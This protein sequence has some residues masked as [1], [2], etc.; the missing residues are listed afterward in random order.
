VGRFR[1][2]DIRAIRLILDER[3]PLDKAAWRLG[4][5]YHGVEQ[6]VA[7]DQLG[8]AADQYCIHRYGSRQ[9][10]NSALAAF[11]AELAAACSAT[12]PASPLPLR[13]AVKVIGGRLKPWAPIF[14]A[15]AERAIPF[16]YHEGS[17]PLTERITIDRS[18]VGMLAD[19]Q[20]E[21]ADFPSYAFATTMTRVDAGEVLNLIAKAYTPLLCTLPPVEG[22]GTEIWLS[23]VEQLASQHIAGAEIG[24]RLGISSKSAYH[25]AQ[26]L[27]VPLLGAAGFSRS[28]AESL[29]FKR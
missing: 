28:H 12:K 17:E 26:R 4:I 7:S 16:E 13:Q 18:S 22:L 24:M 20:F 10:T 9:T 27:S 15:L 25:L 5:S 23:V 2:A 8:T 29:I 21:R 3:D 1:S 19:L 11:E 14:Q 6:L